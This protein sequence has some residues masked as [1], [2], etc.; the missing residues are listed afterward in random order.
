MTI[1]E[2]YVHRIVAHLRWQIGHI[3][4]AV[5]IVTTIDRRLARSLHRY[6]QAALTGAPRIDHKLGRLS[7]HAARQTGTAGAHFRRIAARQTIETNGKRRQWRTAKADAQQVLAD[8]GGREIDEITF[9]GR[10]DMGT[11]LS[12]RRAGYGDS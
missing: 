4:C 10:Y 5:A 12:A 11:D 8:L 1:I 2:R 7:D 9:G 6:A 3:A